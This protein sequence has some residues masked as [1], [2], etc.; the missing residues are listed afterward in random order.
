MGQQGAPFATA[1]EVAQDEPDLRFGQRQPLNDIANG[2]R[3]GPVSAQEFQPR[4]RG[5]EQVPQ[6]DLR[7]RPGCS[8][9]HRSFASARHGHGRARLT[10]RAGRHRQA[11]DRPKRGQRLAPK[12]KTVDGQQV[13][14]VDL[15]S[16]V[17]RQR[18]RQIL[19]RNPVTIVR[20]PDQ[21]LAPIGIVDL[22]AR[23]PGIQSVFDEFLD[24]R[25][26]PLDDFARRDTVDDRLIQRPDH[27]AVNAYLG[28]TIGHTTRDS[29]T[30]RDSTGGKTGRLAIHSCQPETSEQRP[31]TL[32]GAAL[33]A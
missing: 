13:F 11:T 9:F 23:G 32:A 33:F 28:V 24:R 15:G 18:Q 30:G 22:D 8:G 1:R 10:R 25:R 6:L 2:L 19:R 7:A 27:R 16:R 20:H 3:L 17:A 31:A 21:R 12:A 14:T 4:R 26:G 5:K 29:M